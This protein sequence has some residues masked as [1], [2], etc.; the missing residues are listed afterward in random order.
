VVVRTHRPELDLVV[1]QEADR[2]TR[3]FKAEQ[4][5]AVAQQV[6]QLKVQPAAKLD[7]RD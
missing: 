2:Q 3:L 4:L 7:R 5:E 6:Q 1:L